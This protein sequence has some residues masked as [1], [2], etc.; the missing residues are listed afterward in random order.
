MI[1][2]I[3]V[4]ALLFV[5][6]ITMAQTNSSSVKAYAFR[7]TPGQDLK[8]ELENF[9]KLHQIKAAAILTCAGSLTDAHIRFANQQ[10]GKS[11]KGYFEIL[12]LT[13]TLSTHGMHL[14]ISVSDEKGNTIG[15]H[16]LTGNIIYT[17]AEIV[18]AELP[19]LDFK[20]EVDG[21]FGYKELKVDPKGQ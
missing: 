2:F 15:G 14:H 7:L 20:R 5:S 10:E 11:L 16:L 19:D 8:A 17:T 4:T 3:L 6:S 13:G 21:T 9:I 18:I 12:S 1:K